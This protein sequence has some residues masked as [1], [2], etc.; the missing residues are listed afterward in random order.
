MLAGASSDRF[1]TSS[2]RGDRSSQPG[3][4]SRA[5]LAALVGD[6]VA[7]DPCGHGCPEGYRAVPDRPRPVRVDEAGAWKPG[8]SS[9]R[10]AW[11]ADGDVAVP[12]WT[13]EYR[14]SRPLVCVRGRTP[15]Q[16]R[17]DYEA[18]R[19]SESRTVGPRTTRGPTRWGSSSEPSREPTGAPASRAL[20]GPRP[21]REGSLED[22]PLDV[23]RMALAVS[24]RGQETVSVRL[25]PVAS[26][27]DRRN[28]GRLPGGRFGGASRSVA[29]QRR[30]PASRGEP[31]GGILEELL[32]AAG[33]GDLPADPAAPRPDAFETPRPRRAEAVTV[34][35]A[36]GR[37][38][39]RRSSGLSAGSTSSPRADGG[40]HRA[41]HRRRGR[42]LVRREARRVD[43]GHAEDRRG[44]R[45]PARRRTGARGEA[46]PRRWE[47]PRLPCVLRAARGAGDVAG[48]SD[49]RAARVRQHAVQAA[50]RLPAAGRGRR[51]GYSADP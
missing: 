10:W 21:H 19:T 28:P 8:S 9:R 35:L 42:T 51:L 47:Q 2:R 39:S 50:R 29:G 13:P 11:A 23:D 33:P 5:T 40:G 22:G 48:V 44:S 34:L 7:R 15:W 6:R 38:S 14:A 43:S 36:E 25:D 24:F 27:A 46:L 4:R 41:R 49:E 1:L 26:L 32:G 20:P 16:M 37:R 3:R 18:A 12:S 31:T 45:A 30:R 17:R